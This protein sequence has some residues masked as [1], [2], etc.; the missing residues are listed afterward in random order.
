MSQHGLPLQLSTLCPQAHLGFQHAYQINPSLQERA[1]ASRTRLVLIEYSSSLSLRTEFESRTRSRLITRKLQR[2][3]KCRIHEDKQKPN[4]SST[5]IRTI[6]TLLLHVE[7]GFSAECC[8]FLVTSRAEK[9]PYR[10]Q[11]SHHK[12]NRGNAQGYGVLVV[13]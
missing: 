1:I 13:G 8:I 6:G 4:N 11:T 10:S 5:R 2:E 9:D 3:Y 12:H 7:W